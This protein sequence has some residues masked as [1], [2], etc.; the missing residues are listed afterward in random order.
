MER[1]RALGV[2]RALALGLLAMISLAGPTRRPHCL[3]VSLF[4]V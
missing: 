1:I 2:A 3:G 4:L